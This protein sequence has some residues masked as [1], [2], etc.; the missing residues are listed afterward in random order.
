[1]TLKEAKQRIEELER[2]VRELESRPAIHN[3][4]HYPPQQPGY[5]W[6]QP[7]TYGAGAATVPSDEVTWTDGL[8][9]TGTFK[10]SGS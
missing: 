8:G 4:Y 7:I 5:W 2:K 9:N 3:H 1:M 10:L 6:T